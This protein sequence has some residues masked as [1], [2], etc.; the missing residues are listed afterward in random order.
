M[1]HSASLHAVTLHP[2]SGTAEAYSTHVTAL[3]CLA[4]RAR[5]VRSYRHR[6]YTTTTTTTTY[7]TDEQETVTIPSPVR[8]LVVG[9]TKLRNHV[10]A[11]K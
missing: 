9:L 1:E 8:V 3:S 10:F 11:R 4:R 6:V 5:P 7:G 2:F